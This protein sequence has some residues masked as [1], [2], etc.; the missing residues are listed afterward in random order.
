MDD[1]Y[2]SDFCGQIKTVLSQATLSS[3]HTYKNTII[4]RRRYSVNIFQSSK[5]S[6]TN[7][8]LFGIGTFG[9]RLVKQ[10]TVYCIGILLFPSLEVFKQHLH[11]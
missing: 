7:Y 3:L 1:M 5:A 11:N 9:S 8:F 2:Y 4:Y 6:F 10:E